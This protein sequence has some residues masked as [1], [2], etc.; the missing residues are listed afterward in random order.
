MIQVK[1]LDGKWNNGFEVIGH[2]D[3]AEHGKDIV[4]ASASAVTLMTVNGLLASGLTAYEM[5]PGY[6]IVEVFTNGD[7]VELLIESAYRTFKQLEQEYPHH[8]EVEGVLV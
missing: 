1:P 2:A 8:V 4:C 5:R 3:Y 7:A 6:A